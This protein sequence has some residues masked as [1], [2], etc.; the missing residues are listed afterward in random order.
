MSIDTVLSAASKAA[1]SQQG[2]PCVTDFRDAMARLGAAVHIITTDGAVGRAGFTASAVCSVTDSPP[3]VLV[4]INRNSSAYAAT[5]GNRTVCI[6]TLSASQQPLSAAF[7]AKAPMDVRFESGEWIEEAGRAPALR[8][9]IMSLHCRIASTVSV[10][11]HDILLCEVDRIDANPHS[12]ILIY[13]NR[14]YHDIA[15]S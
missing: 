4:C 7:S 11:T 1:Q 14:K 9:A 10:G 5:L 2:E 12:G 8:D 3:S 15:C 6:N 13:Y